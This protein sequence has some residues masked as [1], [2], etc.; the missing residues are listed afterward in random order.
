M[1]SF[2]PP[3]GASNRNRPPPE[4]PSLATEG[5]VKGTDNRLTDEETTY[6][7]ETTLRPSQFADPRIVKFILCYLVCRNTAQAGREAGVNGQYIRNQPEVH[8][9]IEALTAKAV[10]KYGYDASE[11]IERVKEVAGLDPIEFEN[12][13]GSFKTHMSQIA[14]EARRA[15]KKFKAKNLYGEDPNGMKIVIGQLIEVEMWDKLKSLE[16]LGREKN[17][18]KETKKIEHDV[19]QN[20]ADLLLESKRM[21]DHR[22]LEM[23]DVSP[24]IEIQAPSEEA[25]AAY[26]LMKDPNEQVEKDASSDTKSET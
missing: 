24:V 6:I 3:P 22:A 16:L 12:P 11:V 9:A 17:I 23:K 14:P 1:N 18:M 26:Q 10:M 21:A 8:K 13:D 15:I 20:M 19:T 25:R 2:P 5:P 7:L 4:P